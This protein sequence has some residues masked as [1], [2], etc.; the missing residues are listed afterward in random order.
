MKLE[1]VQTWF[2]SKALPF[3]WRNENGKPA[4]LKPVGATTMPLGT[5][6]VGVVIPDVHLGWGNDIFRFGD[7]NRGARL[8]RFL[9]LLA[10]LRQ[11]VKDL[12]IVQLGDWYD[13][14]RTEP[15][16]FAEKKHAIDQQYAG[17][18]AAA[19]ALNVQYCIGNHDAA[20]YAQPPL[21][22]DIDIAIARQLGG[23]DIV[24][25][26]GH[27]FV[28]LQNIVVEAAAD[29]AVV[30]AINIFDTAVPILGTLASWIQ[31]V[32]DHTRD[33]WYEEPTSLAWKPAAVG[34]PDWDAPWVDRGGAVQIG[35][36]IRS[37]E[38]AQ[39]NQH[40]KLAFVGHTHR[41]GISWSPIA[42]NRS[43]PLIDA[44]SWTYGRAEFALVCEDGVGLAQFHA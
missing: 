14:W 32:G 22:S 25:F 16:T 23:P 38:H 28:T 42:P 39:A 6:K 9:L 21:A 34:L 37:A 29:A 18:M 17:I 4:L 13:L 5:M 36:V 1:D 24:C 43:I 40:V 20:F 27:D 35:P 31:M 8:E 26:H 11:E 19:R 41:P 30:Q 10:E 3:T 15:G 44:G 33:P 12:A 2:A 7:P